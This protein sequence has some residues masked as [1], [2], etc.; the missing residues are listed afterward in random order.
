MALSLFADAVICA[1]QRAIKFLQ[2]WLLRHYLI[3]SVIETLSREERV[4]SSLVHLA[5]LSLFFST[6]GRELFH[7]RQVV[8]QL[9]VRGSELFGLVKGKFS[10]GGL[11]DMALLG[12]GRFIL[13][14]LQ[15]RSAQVTH[16]RS[17]MTAHNTA[18]TVC[19]ELQTRVQCCLIV[20]I[21]CLLVIL[22]NHVGSLDLLLVLSC[23]CN[24][25]VLQ[26]SNL[27]PVMA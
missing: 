4:R 6:M 25:F 15:V 5:F 27:T 22:N 8:L 20:H 1:F 18:L 24:S 12:H 13:L 26:G 21:R 23:Q 7:L 19:S 11:I 2:F 16:E 9:L 17:R 14:K 3:A 10:R